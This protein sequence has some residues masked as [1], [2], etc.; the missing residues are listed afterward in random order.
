MKERTRRWMAALLLVVFAA[1]ACGNT[2]CV[3]THVDKDGGVVTHSHPY[4]PSAHHSHSAAQLLTLAALNALSFDETAGAPAVQA[5]Q[6]ICTAT[7]AAE[8][9]A[10]LCA[11]LLKARS[12]RAPPAIA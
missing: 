8:M 9:R 6:Q 12:L 3:H 11:V 7:A 5:P 10:Q 4:L 2:L 1:F